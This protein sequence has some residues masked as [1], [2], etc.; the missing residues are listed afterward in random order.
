MIK[1]ASLIF[2]IQFVI[3]V[4]VCINYRSVAQAQYLESAISE[5]AIATL[6]YL[7]IKKIASTGNSTLQWMAYSFGT[8]LGSLLGI[9]ISKIVLGQ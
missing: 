6:N 7:V 1:Q 3:Y 9:W 2:T 5:F 8:V 4:L